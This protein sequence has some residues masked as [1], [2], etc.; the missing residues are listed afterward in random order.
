MRT[1]ATTAAAVWRETM[2]AKQLETP[3]RKMAANKV[4]QVYYFHA[5]QHK[6]SRDIPNKHHHR[7]K[8]PQRAIAMLCWLQNSR[9]TTTNASIFAVCM[10]HV[11][12][13][14]ALT[15]SLCECVCVTQPP[16]LW[17]FNGITPARWQSCAVHNDADFTCKQARTFVIRYTVTRNTS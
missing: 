11:A 17:Q 10:L 13:C 16:T 3:R 8:R 12:I 9:C 6:G 5:Q 7:K 15:L 4:L 2:F 1:H 14:S